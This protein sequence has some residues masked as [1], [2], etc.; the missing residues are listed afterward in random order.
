M[1]RR[2]WR[3][4]KEMVKENKGLT[5]GVSIGI[6]FVL[7]IFIKMFIDFLPY[8][9]LGLGAFVLYKLYKKGFLG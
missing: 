6:L 7:A 3:E 4:F 8:I 5:I 9:L 1:V 2:K